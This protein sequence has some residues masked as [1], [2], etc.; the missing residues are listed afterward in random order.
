MAKPSAKRDPALLLDM[1]LY[2]RDAL[3]FVEGLD[4]D[5][6]LA[7]DLHLYAV[8]RRVEVIGEAASKVS[9]ETR[10]SLPGIPWAVVDTV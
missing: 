4:Q 10:A 7:S 1:A 9:A 8:M 2:A 3:S 6:F 5:A